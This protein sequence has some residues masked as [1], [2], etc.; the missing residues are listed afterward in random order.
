M[1]SPQ[2]THVGKKVENKRSDCSWNQIPE[3]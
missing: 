2:S 3:S 1:L